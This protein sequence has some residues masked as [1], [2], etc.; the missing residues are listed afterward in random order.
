[1]TSSVWGRAHLR[2]D[3]R[4]SQHRQNDALLLRRNAAALHDHRDHRPRQ[5][6]GETVFKIA[7]LRGGKIAQNARVQRFF[8]QCGLEV[9]PDRIACLPAR[10]MRAGREDHRTG[11]AE[12]GKQQFPK[13]LIDGLSLRVYKFDRNVFQGQKRY[14][15]WN[16]TF[17]MKYSEPSSAGNSTPT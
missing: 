16:A 14:G 5:Q 15:S 1:M 12:M 17:S 13:V 4:G 6:R 7:V 3:S 8:I 11:E 2:T 10:H 9:D